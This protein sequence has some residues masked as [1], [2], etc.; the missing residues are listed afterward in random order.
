MVLEEHGNEGILSEHDG[1]VDVIS[2]PNAA[3][4]GSVKKNGGSGV[5][6]VLPM[7]KTQSALSTCFLDDIKRMSQASVEVP[8]KHSDQVTSKL[9]APGD[10]ESKN[11]HTE[12]SN[13][14]VIAKP[15]AAAKG[16]VK[17]AGESD[18]KKV[19]PMKKTQATLP[20]SFLDEIKR[21]KLERPEKPPKPSDQVASKSIAPDD[22][23]GIS[24][25]FAS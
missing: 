25:D 7:K 10:Q 24:A 23:D 5:K 12:T 18:V 17:K 9:I 4:K 22:T 13:V 1:D 2:K 19:L 21:M 14:D 3:A 15:K 8:S 11:E 6:K 16:S 20:T